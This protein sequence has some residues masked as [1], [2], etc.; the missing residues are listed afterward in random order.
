MA[1]ALVVVGEAY[2]S[3]YQDVLHTTVLD[4]AL[5]RYRNESTRDEVSSVSSERGSTSVDTSEGSKNKGQGKKKKK[6]V[7]LER[8]PHEILQHTTTLREHIQYFVVQRGSTAHRDKVP[9][10]VQRLLDEIS[11]EEQLGEQ[12]KAEILQDE[13]ARQVR[14]SALDCG[15]WNGTCDANDYSLYRISVVYDPETFYTG[16]RE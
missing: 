5:K 3:R 4:R 16:Y 14:V 11:G 9:H 10:T 1:Q 8:L 7:D 15:F 6:G 2:S 13:D 12:I